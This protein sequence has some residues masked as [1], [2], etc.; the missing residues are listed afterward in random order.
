MVPVVLLAWVVGTQAYWVDSATVPE[1]T[2]DSGNLD[3]VINAQQGNPGAVSDLQF[4]IA[5]LSPGES[6]ARS[7]S[8]GNDGD[9]PFDYTARATATDTTNFP[10]QLEWVVVP[11]GA[12]TNTGTFATGNRTGA[13]TGTPTFTGAVGTSTAVVP[14]ARPLAAGAA[15]QLC[16]VVRWPAARTVQVPT[17]TLRLEVVIKAVQRNDG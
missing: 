17:G 11:G 6:F 8:V 5:D 9:V 12:A 7:L 14:A 4:A 15:E 16:V 1:A 2:F 13:C 10:A 3:L